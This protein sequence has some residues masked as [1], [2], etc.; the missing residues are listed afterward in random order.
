MVLLKEQQKLLRMLIT[1]EE[2]EAKLAALNEQY[3]D[4]IKNIAKEEAKIETEGV[5]KAMQEKINGLEN[6]TAKIDENEG[7][8]GSI[9]A[10][11]GKTNLYKGYDLSKELR[12][13]PM[14]ATKHAAFIE[15][16]W[17]ADK[18]VAM[19]VIKS[20]IDA[21][22]MSIKMSPLEISA[23]KAAMQEG[24]DSEGG[25]LTPTIQRFEMLA[26]AREASVALQ[27]A[28]HVPMT[29]DVMTVP[30]ELT[31]V[32][33]TITAEESA[34][35]QTEPT[36]AEVTLTAKRYDGY[37]VASNEV[38]TDAAINGGIAGIL[39]DQFIEAVGQKLDSAVFIGTGD[40]MSGILIGG[41]GYSE[42]FASG[43]TAFSELLED[44]LRGVIRDVPP[45]DRNGAIWMMNDE[46]MWEYVRGLK[47]T[48][49]EYMFAETR[50]GGPPPQSIWGYDVVHVAEAPTISDSA[51]DTG[52]MAFGNMHGVIIGD[53][54]TDFSLFVDPYTASKEFQTVFLFFTRWATAM[55]KANLFSRIVTAAS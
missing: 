14:R 11:G 20:F 24:T 2:D 50:S 32:S 18:D 43:S 48:T 23:R 28:L 49:G 30:A 21:Y 7:A 8:T 9:V 40:P 1:Q 16:R 22:D 19:D 6:S 26:Y 29:S 4:V 13:G 31:K 33:V 46:I 3:D 47:T 39:L 42:V 44:D 12:I 25:Y 53:R 10:T 35:T 38:I 17:G 52:M 27:R 54:L 37:S 5:I 15:K 55:A 36:F 45:K 34:A 51:A 41:A